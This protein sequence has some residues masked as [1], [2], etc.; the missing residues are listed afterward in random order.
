[1]ELIPAIRIVCTGVT[2]GFRTALSQ[3]VHDTLPLPTPTHLI[4]LLGAAAG[5]SRRD[6]VGLYHR[7]KVGVVGTHVS[8][9]EDLTRV[10]K[11][12]GRE[13]KSS[14]LIRENLFNTNFKLWYIPS[15]PDDLDFVFSAFMNPKYA[16]SLGRD[17]EMIRI[18]SVDKV[19]LKEES[20]GLLKNTV[21]PFPLNPSIDKITEEKESMAPL[22]SIPLP[23]AF[24][25]GEDLRRTPVE[26]SNYTFIEGYTIET[27]RNGCL[28]DGADHFFAL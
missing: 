23:R 18:D 22:V 1:M 16:L 7:V 17:D 6:I 8:T 24:T 26:F 15:N 4:G 10:I 5:I 3:S 20:L 11:F 14:L 25:V 12:K 9:Y 19:N 27:T 21:V 28:S 2:N 13:Q